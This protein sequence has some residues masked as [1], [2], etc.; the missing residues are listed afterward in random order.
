MNNKDIISIKGVKDGLRIALSPTEQWQTI[1]EE[2]ANRIDGRLDFFQG[3]RLTIDLSSRPVP[4][5]ELRSLKAMLERRG[6]VVASI[7]SESQTTLDAAFALN[8][9]TQVMELRAEQANKEV[10]APLNSEET[11][12]PGV[13]VKRTLRSGR[14]IH[15]PGHVVI[16]GDVNPG[17]KVIANGDIIVWG[18]LRGSVHAGAQGDEGAVVCA[19]EMSPTQLRIAAYLTTPPER[20]RKRRNYEPEIALIREA[21]LIFETWA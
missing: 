7:V 17:A 5:Y 1:I 4:T 3:A 18:R 13:L 20:K 21:A 10:A 19:L 11:G 16:L 12:T 15:S 6:L 8:L 9:R 14:T 2:L